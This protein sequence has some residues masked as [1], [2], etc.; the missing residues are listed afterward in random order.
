[1]SHENEINAL[2]NWEKGIPCA[3]ITLNLRI[4]EKCNLKCLVCER[5]IT[6]P[7]KELSEEKLLQIIDDAIKLGIKELHLDGSG[8]LFVRKETSLKIMEKVKAYNIKGQIVTNATLLNDKDIKRIIKMG[9]DDVIISLDGPNAKIHDKLRGVKGAFEKTIKT[10]ESFDKYKKNLKSEKPII[11]IAAILTND[12]YNKLSSIFEL[13]K[14]YGINKFRL[15]VLHKRTDSTSQFKLNESEEKEFQESL[16]EIEQATLK[17]GIRALIKCFNDPEIV[18]KSFK[19]GEILK[20]DSEEYNQGLLSIHCHQP[21]LYIGIR[22]DGFVE[23]C[24]GS[25]F[26]KENINDKGLKDIW[27]GEFFKEIRNSLKKK[28]FYT[29]CQTCCGSLVIQSKELKQAIKKSLK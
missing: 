12:N 29:S 26:N 2:L 10:L 18:K 1:M 8:E 14:N 21:W 23:P 13:I 3:P 20:K 24:A 5:S 25:D 17:Y 7:K 11:T 27:Y 16:K 4:T 6:K 22:E 9:W 15:Q 19:M 28:K